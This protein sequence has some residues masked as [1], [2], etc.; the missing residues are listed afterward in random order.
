MPL[1]DIEVELSGG[2]PNSL[3]RTI[4]VVDRILTD[5]SLLDEL[6][7]CYGSDDPVVRLRVSS[8]MKRISASRPLW[9]LPH[10]DLLLTSIAAIDQASTQWTLAILFDRLR[11]H[12][13]QEQREAAVAV[14]KRNLDSSDDWIVQNT[15]MQVVFDWSEFEPALVEWLRPRLVQFLAS[16]RKSVASRAAKLLARLPR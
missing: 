16:P 2:H 1:N 14:M 5:P 10:L 11:E 7:D 6:I 12:L 9:L 3:G 8:A 13:T 4:A 15:T